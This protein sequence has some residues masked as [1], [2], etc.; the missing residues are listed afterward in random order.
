MGRS[1]REASRQA[2]SP[3]RH[4]SRTFGPQGRAKSG[5][6][7]NSGQRLPRRPQF[8][9]TPY[10]GDCPRRPTPPLEPRRAPN[11]FFAVPPRNVAA[12]RPAVRA[13][14]AAG[15]RP[16]RRRAS[17]P[18]SSRALAAVRRRWP[19]RSL[20][21]LRWPRHSCLAR[22]ASDCLRPPSSQPSSRMPPVR[23]RA[24]ALDHATSEALPLSPRQ[25]P[26]GLH[27]AVAHWKREPRH[28]PRPAA[29]L[30]RLTCL[31]WTA[32]PHWKCPP[33]APPTPQPA[34]DDPA[35]SAESW[36][37]DAPATRPVDP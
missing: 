18:D 22:E 4:E 20:R 31:S 17:Q 34:P 32:T 28:Q 25:S 37:R 30:A 14:G 12:P 11:P 29:R 26:H 33:R 21:A 9:Q 19:A 36:L 24:S 7:G 27:P 3:C 10:P 35:T 13:P 5:E 6:S 2:G 8:L 23:R 1:S 16:A 15:A